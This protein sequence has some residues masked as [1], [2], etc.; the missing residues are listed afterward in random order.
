MGVSRV[1]WR[2]PLD[3]DGPLRQAWLSGEPVRDSRRVDL[4]GRRAGS[5]VLALPITS[6]HGPFALV[7]LESAEIDAFPQNVIDRLVVL[8]DD[9]GPQLETALMFEE[10]RIEASSEERDRLAREMHDGIA[11]ELAVLGYQLDQVGVSAQRVDQGLADE[12]L[13]VRT[14]VTT[15]MSELRLSITDLRTTV[16]PTRGLGAALSTYLPAVCTGRQISLNLSL[17]ESPFRLPAE[18]EVA[19]LKAAQLFAQAVR[20]TSGAR[21]L[22]VELSV[23]APSASLTLSSDVPLPDLQSGDIRDFVTSVGGEVAACPGGT[24]EPSLMITLK[25]HD[26]DNPVTGGRPRADQARA[27]EGLRAD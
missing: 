26:D 19:L 22:N 21:A 24:G 18:Q 1:P 14:Q 9:V 13:A 27:P 6:R 2:T 10:V 8:V 4:A 12:V 5:T 7:V 23:D 11:Q 16:R 25:G 15:L 3:H 20:R 17:T